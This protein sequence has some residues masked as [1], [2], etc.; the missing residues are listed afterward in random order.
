M[1]EKRGFIYK[2]NREAP[3]MQSH[4]QSPTAYVMTDRIRIFITVRP[5][6]NLSLITFVDV[7]LDDPSRILQVNTEPLLPLGDPGTFDEFGMTP[8][9]VTR[10]GDELWLYYTGWQRG[11]TVSFINGIGVAVSLDEGRTFHRRY[12]G[13][14]LSI[15]ENEPFSAMAPGI[16]REGDQWHM[17]YGSGVDWIKEN[18]RL[19]PTYLIYYA[20]SQDGIHWRRPNL[21]CIPGKSAGEANTRPWVVAGKELYHMWFSYRG[22][23]DYRDGA[24]SYRIGYATSRDG[25]TWQRDDA[26]A[27]IT[28][29]ATG[30]D[31]TMIAHPNIVDTDYGRYLFYNGN[32]FGASGFGYAQ[33]KGELP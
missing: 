15:T 19:E 23:H 24:G 3:W 25:M 28:T 33:W 13:P 7:A 18:D 20:H 1:W 22:N 5:R 8:S 10:V 6:Q 9:A 27:G 12:R 30:W 26:K 21:C 32:G 2:P 11:Q 4:A 31:S 29:S 16:L 14:V 17:W